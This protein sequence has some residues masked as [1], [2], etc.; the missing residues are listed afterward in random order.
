MLRSLSFAAKLMLVLA[1]TVLI[2]VGAISFW[3]NRAASRVL[4]DYI[5]VTMRPQ[6]MVVAAAAGES[7]AASGNWEGVDALLEAAEEWLTA[8]PAGRGMGRMMPA[9][10]R[11][12]AA[13]VVVDTG[14]RVVAD[15][16]DEHLGQRVRPDL[17]RRGLPITANGR[18]VG[19]LLTV[20]GPRER[21][22]A[23]RLNRS[24]MLAG[25]IAGLSALV[26]GLLLTE[27]LARPLRAVRDA[28]RR[29]GSGEL[30]VRVPLRSEDEVG[31]VAEA[32]NQ[33]AADLERNEQQRRTMMADIAHELRTPLSVIRGQVEALEDG[34]FPL[35]HD[36]L[37]PIRDQSLLLARLVDDLRDLALAEAGRLP[38][39]CDE[40]DL[41]ALA[42]RV[43]AA[44]RPHAHAKG[45]TLTID[46]PAFARSPHARA[47][48]AAEG[49][50]T[51]AEHPPTPSPSTRGPGYS[52][53]RAGGEGVPQPAA[54][55]PAPSPRTRGEGGGGGN[56]VPPIWADAQRIEQVFANLLSNAVRHTP[57][58]GRIN[59]TLSA[60][61]DQVQV[62]IQD[63]GPGIP[64]EDLPHIFD[65]F[66]RADKARSRA[67]GGTGLGL[68]IARRL[69]QAHGGD[70]AVAS[71]PGQGATFTVTLPVAGCGDRVGADR[72]R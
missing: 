31:D 5:T 49:S 53:A 28:A 68:S 17:L 19:H 11:E 1:L 6:A 23:Q 4:Q 70:I 8:P 36:N 50:P 54:G 64:P 15:S 22:F 24:I 7:Y 66:Y 55:L 45:I 41:R 43:V 65:R 20:N 27:S 52:G 69:A 21:E 59:I 71:A 63:T 39:E 56:A 51:A 40:V 32:F 14:G 29:I 25:G 58:G 35:T 30:S 26:L 37:A 13:L 57:E 9:I 60:G 16:S 34:V 18:T 47:G 72:R 12:S 42:H 38:L 33:M 44:F 61:G 2:A 46:D 67:E 10:P 48:G 3:V 62:R